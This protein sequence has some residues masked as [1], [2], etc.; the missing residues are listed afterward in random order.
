MKKAKVSKRKKHKLHVELDYDFKLIGISSHEKDYKLIF[1][2]NSAL[3][4]NFEKQEEHLTYNKKLKI[5]QSFSHYKA[6]EN[7]VI[8]NLLSNR[9]EDG[10]L[11]EEINNID[12]LIQLIGDVSSNER[13]EIIK[14]IKT[15][16]KVLTAI[17]LDPNCLASKHKLVV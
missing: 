17:K 6:E 8:Y 4:L 2:I 1:L 15:I 10:F 11:A 9:C 12:Y 14:K 3:D 16:D 13:N 5:E 7:N